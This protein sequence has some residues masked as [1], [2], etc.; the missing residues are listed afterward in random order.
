MSTFYL[1]SFK[2]QVEIFKFVKTTNPCPNLCTCRRF[3]SEKKPVKSGGK[4]IAGRLSQAAAEFVRRRSSGASAHKPRATTCRARARRQSANCGKRTNRAKR[5]LLHYLIQPSH[6]AIS[7]KSHLFC[8]FHP[9]G[10]F[11]GG[12]D[13]AG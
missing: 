7:F 1:I 4:V 13:F 5:T 9:G 6:I 11:E 10:V 12:A 2:T 8:G 3:K